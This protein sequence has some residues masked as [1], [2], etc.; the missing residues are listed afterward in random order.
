M[1][2]GSTPAEAKFTN[3]AIGS[4]FN[5]LPFLRSSQEQ[6]QHHIIC[7]E[8]PAVTLHQLQKQVLILLKPP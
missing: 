3:L 6:K 7:E 2:L 5:F 1:I 4:R 8:L